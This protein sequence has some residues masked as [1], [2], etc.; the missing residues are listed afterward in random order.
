MPLCTA[1]PLPSAAGS[2]WWLRALLWVP[3]CRSFSAEKSQLTQG[4]AL[5]LQR[6]V[7]RIWSRWHIKVQ[8]LPLKFRKIQEGFGFS[9]PHGVNWDLHQ[10]SITVQLLPWH[11]PVT[12]PS[13][14]QLESTPW[15][16]FYLL[17]SEASHGAGITATLELP[18]WYFYLFVCWG[19]DGRF[20]S[21][22]PN[23]LSSFFSSENLKD[24]N[25]RRF[26]LGTH[27]ESSSF[28]YKPRQF[29]VYKL[30]STKTRDLVLRYCPPS[31]NSLFLWPPR[32]EIFCLTS[33]T[34]MTNFMWL[35]FSFINE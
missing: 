23:H 6:P 24:W 27:S 7:P 1:T 30:I 25:Y 19:R 14:L 15:S 18:N 9:A 3:L 26:H 21:L 16:I 13:H 29:S 34:S 5:L 35:L 33:Y 22:T 4:H 12:F 28:N 17:N 8:L 32:H 10:D 31:W 2:A 20:L 11:N